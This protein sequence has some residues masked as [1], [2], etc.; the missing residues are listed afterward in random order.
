MGFIIE[1]LPPLHFHLVYLSN[2]ALEEPYPV[3]VAVFVMEFHLFQVL[4]YLALLCLILLIL[5]FFLLPLQHI[6]LK[7]SIQVNFQNLLDLGEED[8]EILNIFK[9]YL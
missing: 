3:K 5:Q 4:N 8:K 2:W 7:C 1:A 9:V 6:E